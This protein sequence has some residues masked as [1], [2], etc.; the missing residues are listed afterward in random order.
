M[1]RGG[2]A[3]QGGDALDFGVLGVEKVVVVATTRASGR[4]VM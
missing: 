1:Q 2:P 3:S 4:A